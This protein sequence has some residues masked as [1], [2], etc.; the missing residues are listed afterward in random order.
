MKLSRHYLCITE[1]KTVSFVFGVKYL[2]LRNC[3]FCKVSMC[4]TVKV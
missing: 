2:Y 1:L 4:I 3:Q